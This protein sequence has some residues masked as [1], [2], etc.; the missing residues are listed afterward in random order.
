MC[1][2]SGCASY[3]MD[4]ES[5]LDNAVGQ[6]ADLVTVVPMRE[7]VASNVHD[8]LLVT[9]Y[10]Y[11]R[12]GFCRWKFFYDKDGYILRWEFPDERSRFECHHIARYRP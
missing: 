1:L 8:G 4:F 10:A 9:E 11:L 3:Y 12:D 6:H 5:K 7:I 2:L